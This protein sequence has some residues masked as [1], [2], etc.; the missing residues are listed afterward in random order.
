[1]K[2]ART[3]IWWPRAADRL[4]GGLARIGGEGFRR[5][6]LLRGVRPPVASDT[7]KILGRS[8]AAISGRCVWG[9]LLA[10]FAVRRRRRREVGSLVNMGEEQNPSARVRGRF[11]VWLVDW[12]RI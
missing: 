7:G 4:F 5:E 9:R 8:V 1:M 3:L 6:L 12:R 10:R 11:E 2:I